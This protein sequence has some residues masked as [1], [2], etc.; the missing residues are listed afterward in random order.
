M[1][2]YF[3]LPQVLPDPPH[4]PKPPQTLLFHQALSNYSMKAGLTERETMKENGN[5]GGKT[6][7]GRQTGR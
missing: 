6:D 4:L 5:N 7:E 1:V 2:I 3:V